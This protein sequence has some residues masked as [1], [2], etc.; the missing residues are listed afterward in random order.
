M[1]DYKTIINIA[2]CYKLIISLAIFFLDTIPA[3]SKEKANR[4]CFV[5]EHL[6]GY[7][8]YKS[9]AT[10]NLT[11]HSF[12][13]E[14][15]DTHN[16]KS[17]PLTI[18]DTIVNEFISGLYISTIDTCDAYKITDGDI[19][20][21]QSLV[22]S[23]CSPSD[24]MDYILTKDINE[25]DYLLLC[26]SVLSNLSCKNI[27]KRLSYPC[28]LFNYHKPLF[29]IIIHFS[30]GSNL[31]IYPSSC[32]DGLPWMVQDNRHSFYVR[33]D[34]FVDFIN[35]IRFYEYVFFQDRSLM[36]LHIANTIIEGLP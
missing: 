10:Y 19:E 26:D 7:A 28:R 35:K 8:M 15:S 3:I 9:V 18:S 11:K 14:P 21:Y 31:K 32:Y 16:S 12:I 2:S 1:K 20:S 33:D 36:L 6:D 24:T 29:T 22:H 27:A 17:L 4:I 23:I 25:K 34:Y 13:L 5:Y 30:N